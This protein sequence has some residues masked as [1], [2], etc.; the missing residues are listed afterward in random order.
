MARIVDLTHPFGDGT[1][2]YP[3]LP[4]PVVSEHLSREASRE[5]YAPGTEFLIGRIDMVGNT[6]TYLDTPFHRYPDGTDLATTPLER[7]VEL[8]G[9]V[10]DATGRPSADVDLF[11]GV[12]VAGRA[13]LVRTGWSRN[14][15]TEAYL[16]G[17]PFL[18]AAAAELLAARH[19]ALVG[20]DSLNIDSTETGERPAHSMLLAAAI[21]IVEHLT[22]LEELP[23]EGF[24][25]SAAPAP[26]AGFGTFP[27]RAY[28]VLDA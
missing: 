26:V 16:S 9:L 28:A 18:T 5:R 19:A 24:R 12:G 22:G 6:G 14:W 7:M 4:G 13:V 20:I 25:F 10:V 1:I 3:G 21:P 27:V 23:P 2:T 15:G 17:H 11:E 8:D